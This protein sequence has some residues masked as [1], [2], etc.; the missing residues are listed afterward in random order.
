MEAWEAIPGSDCIISGPWMA[1]ALREAVVGQA[2]V[3]FT[4]IAGR[5]APSGGVCC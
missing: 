2:S 1:T 4:L 5:A 3:V